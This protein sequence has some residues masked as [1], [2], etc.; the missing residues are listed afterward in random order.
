MN[1]SWFRQSPPS[2]REQ[3]PHSQNRELPIGLFLLRKCFLNLF[4]KL[5]LYQAALHAR[6]SRSTLHAAEDSHL[7][8]HPLAL[9]YYKFKLRTINYT[10]TSMEEPCGVPL[11]Y[12]RS[13]EDVFLCG[14]GLLELENLVG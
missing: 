2:S 11:I 6:S 14:R 9:T 4:G 3:S 1:S 12:D 7:N 8:H 10:S 13:V 5:F